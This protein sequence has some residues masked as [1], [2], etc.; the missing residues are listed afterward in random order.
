MID[1]FARD[2]NGGMIV[3]ESGPSIVHRELILALVARHHLPAV[4]P[5]ASTALAIS[6]L[7]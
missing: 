5:K 3:T 1:A 6:S 7:L 4:Y 2:A